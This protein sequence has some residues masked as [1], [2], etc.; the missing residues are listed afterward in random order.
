MFS[1]NVL[2]PFQTERKYNKFTFFQGPEFIFEFST[3]RPYPLP[4]LLALFLV[5]FK[6]QY[7]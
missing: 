2:R 4:T 7:E 1:W 3:W 6:G 5:L